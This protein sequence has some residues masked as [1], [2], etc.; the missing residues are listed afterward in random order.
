MKSQNYERKKDTK[1]EPINKYTERLRGELPVTLS[2]R[3][4]TS[5]VTPGDNNCSSFLVPV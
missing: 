4:G 5:V 3:L 1:S 2:I